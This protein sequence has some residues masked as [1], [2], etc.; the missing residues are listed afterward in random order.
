[1]KKSLRE[2]IRDSRPLQLLLVAC[3]TVLFYMMLSHFSVVISILS[4]IKGVLAPVFIG[5][6]IAY[7]LS[8]VVRFFEN[9]VFAKNKRRKT[10]HVLSVVISLLLML[11]AVGL[12][13]AMMVPQLVE[14]MRYLV[15][16]FESYVDKLGELINRFSDETD[17]QEIAALV[18]EKLRLDEVNWGK[19]AGSAAAWIGSHAGG[20]LGAGASA[21]RKLVNLALGLMFA[22][23]MLLE[24]KQITGSLSRYLRSILSPEQYGR[25]GELASRSNTIFLKYFGGNLLDSLI[26]GVLCLA[27]MAI[28]G[29]PYAALIT[30]VVALTNF[31]PDFG[32]I[33]GAVIGSFL[34]LLVKPVGVVWFLIFTLVS[35]SCDAGIIKPILFGDSTGLSPM[36]VLA[37]IVVGGGL[38]GIAGM[39]LGV[40]AAAI[41]GSVI[42]ER[43]EARLAEREPQPEE[44]PDAGT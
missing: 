22:V 9:R 26:I 7:L 8:P 6:V 12:L 30:V 11:M 4:F 28:S 36:W 3:G 43:M 23:Y 35:Q 32:P 25:L 13:T 41:I 24:Q 27:F 20:L 31:I 29:L 40:P 21:G 2:R 39:L 19:V 37:A 10:A 14:S 44:T 42:R 34:I 33:I 5:A 38:F 1:M 15:S 18:Y 16:N 17:T